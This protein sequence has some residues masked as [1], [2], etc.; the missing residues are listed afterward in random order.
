VEITGNLVGTSFTPTQTRYRGY[1]KEAVATGLKEDELPGIRIFPNPVKDKLNIE[2]VAEAFPDYALFSS[3]GKLVRTVKAEI[4]SNRIQ[5]DL[6]GLAAGI[7]FLKIK[8]GQKE[9]SLKFVKE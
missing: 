4:F 3:E 5:L 9:N 2:G 1:N 6:S 8:T 7:Y